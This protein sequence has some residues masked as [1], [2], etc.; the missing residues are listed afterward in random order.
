MPAMFPTA[1]PLEIWDVATGHMQTAL[2]KDWKH[3][4]EVT[5]SPDG[6]MLLASSGHPASRGEGV[7]KLW[8]VRTG[9][10]LLCVSGKEPGK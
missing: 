3:I 7:Q 2:A 8:D 5:F 10:E 1:G 9:Q 6:T 4:G